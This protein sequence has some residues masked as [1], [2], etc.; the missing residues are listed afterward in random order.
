MSLPNDQHFAQHHTYADHH[1]VSHPKKMIPE[2]Q[3]HQRKTL[4]HLDVELETIHE[5]V[6]KAQRS[7]ATYVHFTSKEL[8]DKAYPFVGRGNRCCY[9]KGFQL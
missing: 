9:G 3:N 2:G 7:R 1:S 5:T 6:T 8:A 4:D